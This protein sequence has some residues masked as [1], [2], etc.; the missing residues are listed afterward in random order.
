MPTR[1]TCNVDNILKTSD[2]MVL[3]LP[4]NNYKINPNELAWAKVKILVV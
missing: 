3:T 1:K 4:P 2:Y